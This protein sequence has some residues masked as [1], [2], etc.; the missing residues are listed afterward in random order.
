[1]TTNLIKSLLIAAALVASA[2]AHAADNTISVTV[3]NGKNVASFKL[4]GSSCVLVDDHIRC[5]S[6]KVVVA[7]NDR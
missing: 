3:E 2:C 6:A 1:M 4:A 5:S 7:D